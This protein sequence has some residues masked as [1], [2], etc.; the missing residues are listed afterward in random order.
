VGG[1]YGLLS[2]DERGEL[3]P[4]PDY[5]MMVLWK[6]LIGDNV[7]DVQGLFFHAFCARES[8]VSGAEMGD[9]SLLLI[10]IGSRDAS[11]SVEFPGTEEYRTGE[12]SDL[13]LQVLDGQELASKQIQLNSVELEMGSEGELPP[14]TAQIRP[15]SDLINVPPYSIM[16]AVLHGV[17]VDACTMLSGQPRRSSGP[18]PSRA[19]QLLFVSLVS[20]ILLAAIAFCYKNRHRY[21]RMSTFEKGTHEVT[22]A[23]L[24]AIS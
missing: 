10:N 16:F 22:V 15:N 11:H 18:L 20:F 9:V 5:W 14:L 13:L 12:R 2:Y 6:K 7:L 23:T 1:N 24:P 17:S 19:N 3:V 8:D 21:K 4:N